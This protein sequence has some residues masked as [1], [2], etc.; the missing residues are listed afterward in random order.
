MHTCT[1][2]VCRRD[3]KLVGLLLLEL[4]AGA[5]NWAGYTCAYVGIRGY[6]CVYV[7]IFLRVYLRVYLLAACVFACVFVALR[8]YLRVY[9][10]TCVFLYVCIFISIAKYN[11]PGTQ[12]YTRESTGRGLQKCM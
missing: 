6:T 5:E 8:V 1:H 3:A 4:G 12:K 11:V 10:N 9:F 7:C 2:I